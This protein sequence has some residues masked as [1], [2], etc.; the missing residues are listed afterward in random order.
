[1]N[2]DYYQTLGV[3]RGATEAEIKQAYRN[4]AKK[5]H[6]DISKD[7]DAEKKFKEVNEAY[8]VLG[9]KNKKAQYDQFGS[10]PSGAGAGSY[11]SGGGFGG[12]DFSN[13]NFD[14]GGFDFGDVFSDFF[15]GGTRRAAAREKRGRDIQVEIS[16]T[17]EEA[18]FGGIREIELQKY[19]ECERCKGNGAEPGTGVETCK[20]CH[21]SGQVTTRQNTLFGAMAVKRPCPDCEGSGER[22]KEKCKKCGGAGRVRDRSQIKVKIPAGISDGAQIRLVGKGEA[23]GRGGKNGDL[24]I[25][26]RVKPSREFSRDGI[27]I[28]SEEVVDLLTAVLG[29]EIKIKT[30]HKDIKLNVPAGT[31]SGKVFYLRGYGI[32]KESGASGDHLVKIEVEIPKKLT[33]KQRQLYKQLK[34][35]QK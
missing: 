10:V 14:V 13:I 27:N 23:A 4:M 20:T 35:L 12:F 2:K 31:Q 15:G 17:F 3:G 24:Y 8:Q 30:I 5:H 11:Q 25:L 26:V 16:L 22:I 6:P 7:S 29:G 19:E 32:H 28:L 34:D 33:T 9:D 21:G 1:M 18:A